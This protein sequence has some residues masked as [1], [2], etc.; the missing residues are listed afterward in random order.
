[1]S[2][3]NLMK[4]NILLILIIS[5]ISC[6]TS[7]VVRESEKNLK[8]NWIL[9]KVSSTVVGELKIKI[10]GNSTRDCFIG[11]RWEFIPNNHTGFY[12]LSGNRCALDENYFKFSIDEVNKTLGS[13][14]FLLK[15]TDKRGNSESNKGYRLELTSL[16]QTTMTLK[17]TVNFEGKPMTLTF[18]FTKQ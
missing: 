1:M 15:P 6:G 13:Y 9:N 11:S 16:N 17:N 18:N 2:N 8:G 12:I 7:K 4:K 3:K 14:D 5:L 10:L